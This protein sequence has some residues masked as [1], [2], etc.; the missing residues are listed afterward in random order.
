MYLVSVETLESSLKFWKLISVVWQ[1]LAAQHEFAKSGA[2]ALCAKR[3][4]SSPLKPQI[5]HKQGKCSVGLKERLIFIEKN[6]NC[7][8]VPLF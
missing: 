8:K 2:A 4:K 1:F 7:L 6:H 5:V 3:F